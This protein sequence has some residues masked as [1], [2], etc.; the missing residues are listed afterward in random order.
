MASPSRSGRPCPLDRRRTIIDALMSITAMPVRRDP[1]PAGCGLAIKLAATKRPASGPRPSTSAC[2]LRSQPG[3]EQRV[4]DDLAVREG[5]TTFA[6]ERRRGCAQ[7]SSTSDVGACVRRTSCPVPGS[8][9]R[10]T[11]DS[12]GQ[13]L[14]SPSLGGSWGR[15]SL[16]LS[17]MARERAE[18][19]KPISFNAATE[20]VCFLP[21]RSR[22]MRTFVLLADTVIPRPTAEELTR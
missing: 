18:G 10:H 9:A 19:L 3:C 13:C 12:A 14:A 5:R 8:T 6:F 4:A 7:Q 21:R 1:L 20:K 17:W 2:R 15:E 22:L 11:A 16:Y